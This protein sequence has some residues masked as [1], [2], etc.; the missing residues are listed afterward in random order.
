MSV[1]LKVQKWP[2]T[3]TKVTFH[4]TPTNKEI[5]LCQMK[6]MAKI[7]AKGSHQKKCVNKENVLKGGRGSIWKPDFFLVRNK[8]I[9]SQEGGGQSQKVLTLSQFKVVS[10][11]VF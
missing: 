3:D 11:K 2:Q 1:Y 4:P 9:F 5:F 7:Q 10:L 8:E 6:G